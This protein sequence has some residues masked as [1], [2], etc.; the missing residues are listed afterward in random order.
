MMCAW[1]D[2]YVEVVMDSQVETNSIFKRWF[3]ANKKIK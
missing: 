3:F 1:L 2:E